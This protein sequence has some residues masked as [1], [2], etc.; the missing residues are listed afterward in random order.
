MTISFAAKA[1]LGRQLKGSAWELLEYSLHCLGH[2]AACDK[3]AA[4]LA[5]TASA[6]RG[7]TRQA[8]ERNHSGA[9]AKRTS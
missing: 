9:L 3:A 1:T 5:L 2:A 7:Q 4:R 8:A 6:R